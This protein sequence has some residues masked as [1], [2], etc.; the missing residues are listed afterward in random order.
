MLQ[1][2]LSADTLVYLGLI[3]FSLAFAVRDE[4]LLRFMAIIGTFFYIAFNFTRDVPEWSAIYS[5]FVLVA[6]NVVLIVT[7]LMERTTFAMG[8]RER[9]LF[10]HFNRLTPGQFRKLMRDAK[11]IETPISTDIIKE[12]R[13]PDRLYF[14]D[15]PRYQIVR[16]GQSFLAEGPAFAGE[17]VFLK[18]GAASATVRVPK[19]TRVVSWSHKALRRRMEKSGN[20]SNALVARFSEDM[21][22]KVQNSVPVPMVLTR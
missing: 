5:N 16:G 11:W 2:V 19:G 12:G 4:L 10:A 7:I 9:A 20:M 22:V 6:I 21:A 1:T 17:V 18:G 3:C 15:A 14:I 13:V 8:E